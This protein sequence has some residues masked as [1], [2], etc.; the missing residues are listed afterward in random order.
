MLPDVQEA[1][2][3]G[4]GVTPNNIRLCMKGLWL[5]AGKI[6]FYDNDSTEF[7]GIHQ[8]DGQPTLA[9]VLHPGGEGLPQEIRKP[10]G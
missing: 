5:D 3:H 1:K 9:H 7:Y 4:K 6:E 8:L 2:P 10:H